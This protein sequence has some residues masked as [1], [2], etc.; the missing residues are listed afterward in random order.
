MSLS[1]RP[2]LARTLL[3]IRSMPPLSN[4]M[5]SSPQWSRFLAH[6][7]CL[8]LNQRRWAGSSRTQS[9]MALGPPQPQHPFTAAETAILIPGEM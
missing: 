1:S 8:C 9:S 2:A 7:H 6:P 4:S 5:Q 3:R